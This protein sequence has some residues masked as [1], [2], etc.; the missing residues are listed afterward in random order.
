MI[1]KL[2]PDLWVVDLEFISQNCREMYIDGDKRA[3]VV[4]EPNELLV[5]ELESRGLEFEE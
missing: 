3:I 4:E 1:V 5:E 2:S